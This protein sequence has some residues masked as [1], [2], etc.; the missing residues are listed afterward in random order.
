M[1]TSAMVLSARRIHAAMMCLGMGIFIGTGFLPINAEGALQKNQLEAAAPGAASVAEFIPQGSVSDVQTVQVSFSTAVIAFGQADA[2]APIDLHCEGPVPQGQGRWL[3]DHRWVYRFDAAVPAGVRCLAQPAADFRD[4]DGRPLV[5]AHRYEFDTGSPSVVEIRPY[6]S[7]TVDEEQVFILRLDSVADPGALASHSHCEVEGI[8]EEIP[9]IAVDKEY[10]PQLAEAAYMPLP[11]NPATMVLLQCAR[12]LPA[13]T[14]MNLVVGPGLRAVGQPEEL[15]A[16]SKSANWEFKVRAA[17]M[18][19]VSC[20]RERAGRPCLPITP[21]T[22]QFSAPVPQT[23]LQGIRLE[24]ADT[25]FAPQNIDDQDPYFMTSL[26]FSGPFPAQ[27]ELTL[28]L[29]EGL[30]DDAGRP[31]ENAERFPQTIQIADYPPLAKF[32][33]GT[34]GVIER[35]ALGPPGESSEAAS[36]PVTVRHVES[37]LDFRELRLTAGDVSRLRKVDDVEVLAWY[38][39]LRRLES[40]RW[41]PEQ[42][43]DIQNGREPREIDLPWSS[44]LDSRGVSL[45]KKEAA[46]SRLAMPEAEPGELRPFEVIGVPLHEPGFHVLEI[47]SPRLGSSLLED[48]QPMYVRSGV[49][50]TNLGV[51]VKQGADDLLVWVTSLADAEPVANAIVA[52]RDCKGALLAEGKSDSQ[53]IWHHMTAVEAPAYC[54]ETGLEGLFVS[55]RIGADHP[56]AFGKEDYS[57]VMSSW[58]RGIEPWRF[59]VPTDAGRDPVLLTHTVFDRSLFRAGETVHMKHYVREETRD[60]LRSPLNRR[61]DRLLIEHEGSSQVQEFAVQWEESPSGGLSALSDFPIPDSARLGTYSV[62]L[63][64]SDQNWYGSTRFRVEEFRLPM[65]AGQLSIRGRSSAG[66]LVAPETMSLDMQLAWLSGGPAIG[67]EIELNAVA[68]HTGTAIP[69]FEDYSFRAP[70]WWK[71]EGEETSDTAAVQAEAARREVFVDGLKFS[72]DQDG[73]GQV[74]LDTLPT[75]DEM[76]RFVFEASFADPNGEVQ[77]LSQSV[78]VWPSALQVGIQAPGWERQGKS[79]PVSMIALSPDAQPQEGVAVQLMTVHRRTYTVRKRMVGGFYRYD[80]HTEHGKAHTVCSG[81]TD[82]QGVLNCELSFLQEGSFELV[83]VTEDDEGRLSRAYTTVWV[84]G[85]DGLWFGGSDDDRIDIIPAKQEWD[86]G[87]E[88]EF[89][90]RMPFREAVALVSVEREGVL[91]SQ[92][93]RL[94]GREPVIRIPVSE[95]WGPNA[96]VSVL[97]LRGRLY[98]LP[99]Q[100]FFEGGW[101]KPNAWLEKWKEGQAATQVTTQIDLAKPALRVGLAELRLAEQVNRLQVSLTPQKATMKVREEASVRVEVKLPDGRPASNG[102]VTFIAVDEALLEL[103]PN[104][105]WALYEGL[106]PRRSLWVGTASNQLEVV[107][108]RHYGRKAVAAGGGGGTMPTRQLFDTLLSWQPNV[109]LDERGSAELTFRMNDSLSRFR[110][111]ALAE[112]DSSFFGA[113][114]VSVASSQP[115]QLVSG[116]PSVVRE[117]DQYQAQLTV[118]N[119]SESAQDISVRASHDA[120]HGIEL[121]EKTIRLAPGSAQTLAWEVTAPRLDWTEVSGTVNWHFAANAGETSDALQIAQ[122]LEA[123]VPIRSLQSTLLQVDAGKPVELPVQVPDNAIRREH[124]QIFGGLSL[125]ISPTLLGS[126]ETVRDWWERYPYSCFE[127]TASQA[128]AL[129]DPKRWQAVTRRI[130]SYT[131]EDGLLRYFPGVGR[132]SAVLTAYFVSVSHEAQTLGEGMPIPAT[133]LNRLLDGLQAFAEGRIRRDG[134][135]IPT[136]LDARRVMAMEALAR[137][138]RV[139][140][141]MLG[142]IHQDYQRWTTPVLVDWLSILNR[143]PDRASRIGDLDQVRNILVSRMTISGSAMQF[144]EGSM[145]SAPGLMAT[146]VTSLARLILAVSDEAQWREDV[147]RLVQGLL[148]QQ[149]RGAWSMTTENLLGL[150]ALRSYEQQF[151]SHPATGTLH[152]ELQGS[153]D[154]VTLPTA[155]GEGTSAESSEFIPNS[156]IELNW[157]LANSPLKLEH[158]GSGT[159]WV[160]VQAQAKLPDDRQESAGFR[161]ERRIT[162]VQQRRAGQWSRGDIYR[163]DVEI[164]TPQSISWTVLNDPI[165][166]GATILGSGLGRDAGAIHSATSAQT[167]APT[168]VER[169]QSAYRAYFEYLPAGRVAISYTVRLNATGRFAMPSTRIEALYQPDLHGAFPNEGVVVHGESSTDEIAR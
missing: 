38:A 164:H 111:V 102:T 125:N 85:S 103:A 28:T 49:L 77:T 98:S 82:A 148:A 5:D 144:G 51:H 30:E 126:L 123:A 89:Q 70:E 54:P 127:Q 118:R 76:R 57:F 157:P 129:E 124:N 31:L 15:P 29:P 20:T 65:L 83:A 149:R 42:I 141:D 4:L 9:V 50:L 105:S 97:V 11:Q 36:V 109:K 94:E 10:L 12:A 79:I 80:S 145:N 147:P 110:L 32:A 67:Q 40:G 26:R 56:Q 168:F 138:G 119:G 99:W 8:G 74:Q 66:I 24:G 116:L 93:M 61:P 64:D 37:R 87:E 21:I 59:D 25:V 88:A 3:D 101:R 120:L 153:S 72:L 86:V 34:F 53:G 35:F 156:R 44:R 131:D 95:N 115:L 73:V 68:E 41:S 162:P 117:G 143:M 71:E 130:A 6:E 7:S 19:T 152:I 134:A 135:G 84:S 108:R 121:A 62:R 114:E 63:T 133:D 100:S 39:R 132:G 75:S 142:S 69:G 161:V 146:P 2:R 113:G 27:T 163:V 150:L 91:W 14:R 78:Q 46:A 92:V 139:S 23:A 1:R 160:N 45:L 48:R 167:Y 166:A 137:Y 43:Q 136:S 154:E 81:R 90:V 33:S 112:L 140:G 22:V 47:E 55:A 128:M 52:V 155:D 17:F 13:D 104:E 58:D 107:G 122:R 18:A 96:F 165:P 16:S 106:H 159:A 169:S 158:K 151:E 60:G